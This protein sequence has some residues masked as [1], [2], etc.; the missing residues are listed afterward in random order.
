MDVASRRR[1]TLR[2]THSPAIASRSTSSGRAFTGEA[3]TSGSHQPWRSNARRISS[4]IAGTSASVATVN[5]RALATSPSFVSW[6]SRQRS[7]QPPR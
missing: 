6:V 2:D 4:A 7:F 5:D 3:A 1:P